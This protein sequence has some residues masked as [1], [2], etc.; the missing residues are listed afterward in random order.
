[1]QPADGRPIE[2]ID[3]EETLTYRMK[4]RFERSVVGPQVNFRVIAEDGTLA[5]E[6]A[7]TI[8][9]GWRSFAEGEEADV[10]VTFQPRFGGGGTFRIAMVVTDND[11][12]NVLFHDHGGPSFFVPPRIGVGGVADLGAE[13]DIDGVPRTNHSSLRLQGRASVDGRRS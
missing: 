9:D 3:Q 1:L 12:G 8:G 2:S 4:L 11:Y 10:A 5:Y 13:I 7:T 6:R